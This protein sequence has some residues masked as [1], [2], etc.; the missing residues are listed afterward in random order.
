MLE[1]DVSAGWEL[2]AARHN[3]PL[4]WAVESCSDSRS[5]APTCPPFS[6]CYLFIPDK[7]DDTFCNEGEETFFFTCCEDSDIYWDCKVSDDP[8]SCSFNID[9]VKSSCISGG[10]R[11]HVSS[12]HEIRMFLC[13]K[14]L[15]LCILT[16]CIVF[17]QCYLH[18]VSVWKHPAYILTE[19]I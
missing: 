13:A 19:G 4:H 9:P 2:R 3:D 15:S 14:H 16:L 17:T 12:T 10:P 5:Y 6:Y 8:D 11:H 7:C 18:A 1:E